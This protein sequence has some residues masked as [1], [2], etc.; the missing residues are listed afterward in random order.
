[1]LKKKRDEEI[2]KF[3]EERRKWKSF[4]EILSRKYV[5]IPIAILIFYLIDDPRINIMRFIKHLLG[6]T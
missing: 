1:M 2:D 6:L 5:Y 3:L 4:F